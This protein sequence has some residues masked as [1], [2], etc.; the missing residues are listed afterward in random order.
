MY[1]NRSVSEVVAK[2]DLKLV[3]KLGDTLAPSAI[4]QARQ[5]L[6]DA[7]LQAL[8]YIT[9]NH[10]LPREDKADTW[11]GLQLF[12]IDGTQLRCADSAETAKEFGYIT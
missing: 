11:H 10:W 8:Y 7:P 12:S 1:R 5:R 9:A 6:T 3:D 4:P 2:L